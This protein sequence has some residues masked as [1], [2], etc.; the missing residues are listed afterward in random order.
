[1]YLLS[2]QGILTQ[3]RTMF[4]LIIQFQT[5]QDRMYTAAEEELGLRNAF[6]D[7]KKVRT[8]RGEWAVSEEEEEE[9]TRRRSDFVQTS[10][11]TTRS[12][13]RVLHQSYQV[14][15]PKYCKSIIFTFCLT[16]L[17]IE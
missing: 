9:E 13:L 12:Q 6:A 2:F 15:L 5:I 10:V 7:R 17:G 14:T 4:D 3:L 11:P 1:M 16:R 8:E